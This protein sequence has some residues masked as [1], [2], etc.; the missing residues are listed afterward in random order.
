MEDFELLRDM[1][2]ELGCQEE[3]KKVDRRTYSCIPGHLSQP[4]YGMECDMLLSGK[5]KWQCKRHRMLYKR[6]TGC[7]SFRKVRDIYG[8]LES[9]FDSDTVDH[10][11]VRERMIVMKAALQ[12][13]SFQKMAHCYPARGIPE[14]WESL[15]RK[16]DQDVQG[17][18]DIINTLTPDIRLM[19]KVEKFK[20]SVCFKD[21][22]MGDMMPYRNCYFERDV[23]IISH[24]G[25]RVLVP[26]SLV[27]CIADKC[28]SLFGLKYYWKLTDMFNRYPNLEIFE[29]GMTLYKKFKMLRKA[30][31][32]GFFGFC[33]SFEPLI[34][35]HTIAR[36]DDQGYTDLF[37]HQREEM[38][39]YLVLA[40][41]GLTISDF[42]PPDNASEL[43]IRMW[44][45]LTG[46]V[47]IMGYPILKE[48]MLL[49]QL[50]QH[51]VEDHPHFSE[52]TMEDV[53]GIIVRD[54]C[55]N[56]RE[57]RG[58]YPNMASCPKMIY[59]LVT[60]DKHIPDHIMSN[61]KAWGEI[62]FD[63][64]LDFDYSPDL[65]D[66]TKDSA[67][68]LK[69]SQWPNLFD[70]CAFHYHYDKSSPYRPPMEDSIVRVIDAFL[71]AEQDLVRK[72]IRQRENNNYD[73]EDHIIV[74][75]GKELEH[76]EDT[77][78]AFT[79][80][81]PN[82]RFFQVVLEQNIAEGIFKFV[83]EQSMT[84]G[85]VAVSNRYMNQY[86]LLGGDTDFFNCDLTKWCLNYRCASVWRIG[87]M[88]DQLYGLN[89]IYEQSHNFFVNASVFC[90][91]R[92]C[93]PDFDNLG[94][95]KN[96]PFFM[97]NFV[98][99]CEGMHQKKWTHITVGVIKLALERAGCKGT[100]MGQ[101]DNQ[102]VIIRYTK[103]QMPMR[104]DVR[105]RFL[106]QCESIF[107]SIG[108]RL[109]RKE[110]WYS[111]HLHEYGKVRTYKGATV[112]QGTK[113]CTKLVADVNDGLFAHES[114]LST[115][116]TQTEAIAKGTQNAD[117]AFLMNQ[118]L[119]SNYLMRKDLVWGSKKRKGYNCRRLMMF[120]TDFGGIPIST[121]HTHSVRGHD[122][123]VTLWL[124][125]YK[126][127]E[128]INPDFFRDIIK[129]VQLYPSGDDTCQDWTRLIEDPRALRI[130]TLPTSNR[131]ISDLSLRYLKSD[132][133]TNPAIKRLYESDQSTDYDTLVGYLAQM[134]PLFPSLA[135]VILKDS[136]AGI[137]KSLQS[138][139]TNIKTIEKSA[140]KF[141]GVSL[142]KMVSECNVIYSRELKSRCA[143]NKEIR[144][145]SLISEHSCP[146][147]VAEILRELHWG[148]ELVGSTKPCHIH[149]VLL[150]PTDLCSQE[151]LK[152]SVLIRLSPAVR[153]Q[154]IH[155]GIF[156]FGPYKGYV[157]S[158]TQVK[159]KHASI[160]ISSNTSYTKGLVSLG[161]TKTWMELLG[162][163]ELA[164]L[165]DNLMQEK[166]IDLS[167]IIEKDQ[168]KDAHDT[169][170]SGNP[171]HR[172]TSQVESTCSSTNGLIT[173]TS[174]FH[175][176]SNL[177]QDMTADG[178]DHR[179][180]FQYVYSGNMACLLSTLG[181]CELP[182]MINAIFL[183]EGCT[184]TLPNPTF[185]FPDV[186][187]SH[188]PTVYS[189][190]PEVSEEYSL[191][192]F[193]DAFSKSLG[194]EIAANV[195]ENF[196]VNHGNRNY[197]SDDIHVV[198][199]KISINDFK[200]CPLIVIMG[201]MVINSVHCGKLVV[202]NRGDL[203]S[204]GNDLS[205]CGLAD[206]V[207]ESDRREE[208]FSIMS[209]NVSEHTM[210]T[211]SERLSA[212]ISRNIADFFKR[213]H[214]LIKEIVLP[215][216]YKGQRHELPWN[217]KEYRIYTSMMSALGI[218]YPRRQYMDAV[219]R[220]NIG[221]ILSSLGIEAIRVPVF[222]YEV[223]KFWRRQLV[224]GSTQVVTEREPTNLDSLLFPLSEICYHYNKACDTRF[225]ADISRDEL[226]FLCRPIMSL[227]S[228][229]S[230][231]WECLSLMGCIHELKQESED[232]GSHFLCLAEG[233]AGLLATLLD[234]FRG[235]KGM[236]NSIMEPDIDNRDI[237]NDTKPPAVVVAGLTDRITNQELSMGETDITRPAFWGKLKRS[238]EGKMISLA[239]M[240]AESKIHDD[241]ICHAE[242]LLPILLAYQVRRIIFKMFLSPTLREEI[243]K[244]LEPYEKVI[245]WCLYKPI[246]SNPCG[247]E[248]FLLIDR[249]PPSVNIRLVDEIYATIEAYMLP[250]P[251][252]SEESLGSYIHA[253][254]LVYRLLMGIFRGS[255]VTHGDRPTSES[256]CS[257]LCIQHIYTLC[258]RIYTCEVNALLTSSRILIRG[259]GKLDQIYRMVHDLTFLLIFL[260][261][262]RHTLYEIIKMLECIS[263]DKNS[264]ARI[265][266]AE[267]PNSI[268]RLSIGG[269]R[270]FGEWSDA[271]FH[272]R[273]YHRRRCACDTQ[274]MRP[275]PVVNGTIK[276]LLSDLSLIKYT[277][278]KEYDDLIF[279]L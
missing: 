191:F 160:N 8:F 278:V 185:E 20:D 95:P 262:K 239:T 204:I 205:F 219:R 222:R 268:V 26:T 59:D 77:G 159:A 261:K 17:A 27:L 124:S 155:K 162:N 233:S 220:G 178:E 165:C 245:S 91:S 197:T 176:T 36:P 255:Q 237:A 248:I 206:L 126:V 61:Y 207:L 130:R 235:H 72:I 186:N 259:G 57:K 53:H 156:S 184:T 136:N 134:K 153:E 29:A 46:M 250:S 225:R 140:Q 211:R 247:H 103:E 108:H 86:K 88:Y 41:V 16:C 113:K 2:C 23:S 181:I 122:D 251:R 263:I 97:D 127:I 223:V 267:T 158:K 252:L 266:N 100:M 273:H 89:G 226:S 50:K 271:K 79:K 31:L 208:L 104:A 229:S 48:E 166:M 111:A 135:N 209:R 112:S 11:Q 107:R 7:E 116:N 214:T 188:I 119:I 242:N 157:G 238:L 73:E 84:D 227:S 171:F 98:G 38:E 35:G 19:L 133:V 30:R 13:Y 217:M 253:S 200:R 18:S 193:D 4:I 275:L 274:N 43:E 163:K 40:G 234:A 279:S 67:A 42:L 75:C 231:Y 192:D 246:S 260:S 66:I 131:E 218:R 37:D 68:A 21:I 120:P 24:N 147:T 80:Q 213:F 256:S 10:D 87:R 143:K 221:A 25:R 139:F 74:Q 62:Q 76:K 145:L 105:A 109:K 125:T 102:I 55:I 65:S 151:E 138:K 210:V 58:R 22:L 71:K 93:P 254:G 154:D 85:E 194:I 168:L 264:I 115:T 51:G 170:I 117:I 69:K 92:L 33:A 132:E 142:T 54:F 63:K 44:L 99:G 175:Q 5:D 28:Q 243:R 189:G 123:P 118:A 90:N 146:T 161:R 258:N 1:N 12:N 167:N 83:P 152:R 172:L 81:T 240:D 49:D 150:K 270:Y 45:E 169:V 3:P 212:Y 182:P 114:G 34:V 265:I 180:F 183:C 52:D 203:T 106:Q 230:K 9:W 173:L 164:K 244:V 201:A 215:I 121:Y 137:G 6:V 141:G 272:L 199:T 148:K 224:H 198:K 128:T 56:Y 187:L 78:R 129:V 110:T 269:G 96:G 174:H 177:M 82:Q 249:G 195:D 32:D 228:A 94:N 232:G 47:K 236:Y 15:R 60:K 216:E 179:I 190:Q 277:Y 64:T 241:N 70:E 14:L 196:K 257:L 39:Q 276:Q 101:G 202:E 149:Q 144:N